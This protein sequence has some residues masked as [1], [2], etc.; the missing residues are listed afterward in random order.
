MNASADVAPTKIAVQG[1]RAADP[2]KRKASTSNRDYAEFLPAALEIATLPP[3]RVVPVLL[4]TIMLALA[5]G[6]VWSSVSVLDVYTSA[7]GL[8]LIHI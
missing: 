4:S 5:A 3:P 2:A 7:A 6:L 1:P 8:S